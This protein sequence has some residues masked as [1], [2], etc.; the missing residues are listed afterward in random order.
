MCRNTPFGK[1]MGQLWFPARVG[2]ALGL[3]FIA[4]NSYVVLQVLGRGP[5]ISGPFGLGGPQ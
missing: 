2:V 1:V 5:E 3:H 4:N